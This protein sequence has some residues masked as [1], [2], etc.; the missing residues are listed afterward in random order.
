LLRWIGRVRVEVPKPATSPI[1]VTQHI[2][3]K[4]GVYKQD[5]EQVIALIDQAKA[6]VGSDYKIA[7]VLGVPRQHVSAWRSGARTATPEDQALLAGLAGLEASSWL[8]RAT[9]KKHEGTAKGDQL[10]R[11]LGKAS[12]AIGGAVASSGA[13]AMAIF[14]N[15]IQ[16]DGVMNA[17][18]AAVSTMYI[19]L[20]LRTLKDTSASLQTTPQ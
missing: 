14:G 13:S 1:V 7:Q 17:I 19:M 10:M 3:T 15:T 4:R 2:V 11:V 6:I 20:S 16:A 9:L 8:V 5:H 18:L 12:L